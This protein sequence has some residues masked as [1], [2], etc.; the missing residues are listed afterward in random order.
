[1]WKW[2]LVLYKKPNAKEETYVMVR[3]HSV[4]MA[5][6][7]AAIQCDDAGTAAYEFS[8]REVNPYEIENEMWN[9]AIV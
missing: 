4:P 3:S 5:I 8:A 6:A 9:N 2:Y 1:M 7:E